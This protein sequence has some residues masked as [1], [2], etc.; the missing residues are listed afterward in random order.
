MSLSTQATKEIKM[1]TTHTL[2]TRTFGK[3]AQKE[4]SKLVPTASTKTKTYENYETHFSIRNK[5]GVFLG[6][7]VEKCGGAIFTKVGN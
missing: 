6:H 1:T 7:V 3:A 2:S 5:E 4:V